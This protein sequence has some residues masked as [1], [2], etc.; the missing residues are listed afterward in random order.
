MEYFELNDGH[1]MPKIGLGT[2]QGNY[3]YKSVKETV[4]KA[5]KTAVELGFRH[6]D[7]AAIYSTE[8][9]VGIAINEMIGAKQITRED[10]F[11]TTK[12]W[13][14]NRARD[15]VVPGLRDS[16]KTLGLDYVDMFLIHWPIAFKPGD[17]TWPK[18]EHGKVIYDDSITLVETWEG[19]IECQKLGLAKSIGVSNF[20]RRQLQT[21]L[22]G[23]SV[24]PANQQIEVHPYFSNGKMVKMCQENGIQVTCFSPLSKPARPW[25]KADDPVVATDPTLIAVGEKYGK[26]PSQV[27]LKF[28][29]QRGLAVVPKCNSV[30][31]QKENVSIFD[32]QLSNGD[33]EEIATKCNRE[34]RVLTLQDLIGDAKEFPFNEEY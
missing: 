2:F 17:E 16:L 7:T 8:E 12:L 23:S 30:D 26:T 34:M 28:L 33:M 20:N 19:M 15:R 25:A 10:I 18:D 14:N 21:L 3:D 6:V 31:H 32:F 27:A 22:D 24:K 5:V 1:R 4:I 9:P 11:V 13:N 29:I